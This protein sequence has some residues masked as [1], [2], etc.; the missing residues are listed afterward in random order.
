MKVFTLQ[1]CKWHIQVRMRQIYQET[2]RTAAQGLTT[3]FKTLITDRLKIFFEHFSTKRTFLL[4]SQRLNIK[5]GLERAFTDLKFWIIQF[6]KTYLNFIIFQN[7]TCDQMWRNFATFANNLKSL[8]I[9]C[10][11]FIIWPNIGPTQVHFNAI[12]QIFIVFNW[13]NIEQII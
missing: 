5:G 3:S 13:T 11:F 9:F 1:A 8:A 10:W 2:L 7:I 12:G 4:N 6:L